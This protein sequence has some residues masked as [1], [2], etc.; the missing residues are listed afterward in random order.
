MV[1]VVGYVSNPNSPLNRRSDNCSLVIFKNMSGGIL[2]VTEKELLKM[3]IGSYAC[4][5]EGEWVERVAGGW[6]YSTDLTMAT[7]FVPEPKK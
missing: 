1:L 5:G 2:T 4:C 6:L 7:C 3:E